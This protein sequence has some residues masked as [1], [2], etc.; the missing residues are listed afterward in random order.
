[1]KT[2]IIFGFLSILF[3]SCSA[4]DL[5]TEENNSAKNEIYIFDDLSNIDTS[6]IIYDQVKDSSKTKIEIRKEDEI[7]TKLNSK[8]TVQV[9]AFSTKEK[10]ENF[11]KQN[12]NKTSF[13]LT[14]IFNQITKLYSVQIP[15][16]ESKEEA[17]K[18]RD[19]LKNFPP[20]KDAFTIQ[21]DN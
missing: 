21:L 12:Q 4:S 19:I 18:I 2:K 3:F 5:T 6:K 14:V 20:F 11:I 13:P 9:G 8:F 15:P 10:A 16:Y 7:N 17:D 1:M